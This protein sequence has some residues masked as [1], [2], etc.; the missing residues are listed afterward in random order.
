MKARTIIRTF[1]IVLALAGVEAVSATPL[2]V[3]TGNYTGHWLLKNVTGYLSG[4]QTL[5]VPQGSYKL[6]VGGISEFDVIIDASGMVSVPNGVSAVG[7]QN[8]VTFK[9]VV[10]DVDPSDFSGT[11]IVSRITSNYFSGPYSLVFVP[12]NKYAVHPAGSGRFDF[13]V[14]GLG[15]VTSY[16]TEAAVGGQNTLVF[17][18]V[19][20]TIDPVDFDGQTYL[21]RVT[22]YFSQPVDVMLVSGI[23]YAIH[24]AGSGRFDFTIDGNGQVDVLNGVSALGG[25]GTLTFN[26][27]D[28][29]IEPVDF[30]GTSYLS[31]VTDYF[32]APVD[33]NVVPGVFY[34]MRPTGEGRFDFYIDGTGL[35]TVSNGVSAQGGQN[36]LVFNTVDLHVDPL[37]FSGTSYLNRMTDYFSTPLDLRAVPGVTYTMHPSGYGQFCFDIDA[38]G[39]VSA[40][41]GI[42]AIGAENYLGLNTVTVNVDPDT[43]TLYYINRVTPG[44]VAGLTTLNLVPGVSYKLVNGIGSADFSVSEPCAVLPNSLDVNGTVF[45]L[46]CGVPDFDDDGV[47]DTTDN[48]PYIANTDQLDLDIDG[49]GDACDTDLDGDGFDNLF[50][51][52][53]DIANSDQFDMD[54]DGLGDACDSDIDGDAVPDMEDNCPLIANTGQANSD[55]DSEGDACDTDDDNDLV[56]DEYDNC[57]VDYNPGQD[58]FDSDGEGDL[59]DGDADSDGIA[60]G[61]DACPASP[62][63]QP[64][65]TEGCP[66]AQYI[67][68]Q[69]DADNYIQHG[70]YVSCVAHATNDAWQQ[71]LISAK[72]KAQFVR[73]AAN[74]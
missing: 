1:L 70:Q 46:N 41:N 31:R 23:N 74:R 20:L 21:S 44:V 42:S 57:P 22:D 11:Y 24:P 40:Q 69:C 50:D 27:V 43:G 71:G 59:C 12:G 64:V 10:V 54:G 62:A 29:H 65:N 17:N 39:V 2:V 6:N 68:Q 36:L 16:N 63:G 4:S 47:P 55:G 28:L 13:F 51:N 52:C 14:D 35:V 25:P 3:D 56:L 38:N 8:Q 66:G 18:T 9:T 45:S 60:N 30:D 32:G 37:E 48:C 53:P 58:D 49:I 72:Q 73:E 7:G 33:V 26:T 67:A 34:A 15:Q 19:P 5:D 61:F